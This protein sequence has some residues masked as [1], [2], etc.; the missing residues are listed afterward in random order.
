MHIHSIPAPFAESFIPI[1]KKPLTQRY[2]SLFIHGRR[3][4]RLTF[5]H[6]NLPAHGINIILEISSILITNACF[7][8]F[9]ILQQHTQATYIDPGIP[10]LCPTTRITGSAKTTVLPTLFDL[11]WYEWR[12]EIGES[13]NAGGSGV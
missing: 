7:E 4:D 6:H 12:T 2:S 9:E 3:S 5:I 10:G 11:N 1:T 8:R 13:T